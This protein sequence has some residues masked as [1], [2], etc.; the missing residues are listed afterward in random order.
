VV[1]EATTANY[2]AEC[3]WPDVGEE[4][5]ERGAERIRDS[6]VQLSREGKR[7]T[8]AG[9]ILVPDDEVVFYL[10]DGES[11]D[12]VREVCERAAIAFERIVESVPGSAQPTV[13]R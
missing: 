6:V 12:A 13:E 2:M 11:A 7:V 9:S 3:F 8:F 4:D 5:I 1:G 10:F